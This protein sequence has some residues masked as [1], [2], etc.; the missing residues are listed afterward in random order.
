MGINI[1]CI[2]QYIFD[3]TQIMKN[4]LVIFLMLLFCGVSIAQVGVNT[5]DPTSTLDVNGTLRV[6]T[7]T[8]SASQPAT[9]IVGVDADGNLT[10]VEGGRNIQIE[11]NVINADTRTYTIDRSLDT[12]TTEFINN[13]IVFPGGPATGSGI[14][15]INTTFPITFLTGIEA[16]PDGTVVVLYPANGILTLLPLNP[17]SLPQNQIM[18]NADLT[19]PLGQTVQ[20]FYNAVIQKWI[21]M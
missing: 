10:E 13:L 15:R 20:L 1:F 2:L 16:A 18:P 7:L 9:K 17:L 21:V 6:R 12:F 5:T 11:E 14:V 19:V 3:E 8:I 4:Y